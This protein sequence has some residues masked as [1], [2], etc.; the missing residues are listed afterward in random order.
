MA[1]SYLSTASI[2]LW[3]ELAVKRKK[4]R[5]TED[6]KEENE[7]NSYFKRHIPSSMILYIIWM[8]KGKCLILYP[9]KLYP[10]YLMAALIKD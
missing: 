2:S 10:D 5:K 8:P 7:L 9:W 6:L 1:L 3:G 4:E